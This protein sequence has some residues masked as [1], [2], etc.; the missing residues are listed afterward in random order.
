MKNYKEVIEKLFE[1]IDP[2]GQLGQVKDDMVASVE[3]AVQS[4]SQDKE[5]QIKALETELATIKSQQGEKVSVPAQDPVE[6]AP[7]ELAQQEELQK[8]I[9]EIEQQ[10]Q[11]ASQKILAQEEQIKQL[12]QQAA[13]SV[14]IPKEQ[15]EQMKQF[16]QE[17]EQQTKQAEEVVA[18]Q[19]KK[20]Q[21]LSDKLSQEQQKVQTLQQAALQ[22]VES[23]VE[24]AKIQQQKEDEEVAIKQTQEL[25]NAIDAKNA[26]DR[27]ALEEAINDYLEAFLDD[28]AELNV[29]INATALAEAQKET[30]D[31]IRDL[32]M[33]N[34]LFE[35]GVRVKAAKIMEEAKENS[36][37]QLNEAIAV[38]KKNLALEKENESLKA[39]IYL[40]EKV[41]FLKP[42]IAEKLTESMSGKSIEEIDKEFEQI[43]KK[44]EENEEERRELLRRQAA[45]HQKKIDKAAS[46]AEDITEP[47]KPAKPSQSETVPQAFA[48]LISVK[49][50]PGFG[51]K[52]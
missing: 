49:Q 27:K 23:Q 44:L 36:N 37:A 15:H 34:S 31:K 42:S 11:K 52:K 5:A 14:Q 32:L 35:M 3:D 7:E 47:V 24:A 19:E 46:Q 4:A 29:K 28:K 26:E 41:K 13:Q 20:I 17:I 45:L 43:K 16:V 21:E 8:Y 18:N 48:K 2:N 25:I 6:P 33:E 40:A 50:I 51:K 38:S 12:K 10:T 30:F 22:N 39:K 9:Q 1:A